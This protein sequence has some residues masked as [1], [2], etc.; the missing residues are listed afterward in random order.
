MLDDFFRQTDYALDLVGPEH[1]A[2]GADIFE[3]STGGVGWRAVTGQLYP[4][5]SQGMTYET[6]NIAGFMR[7][8][9]FPA[10]FE[11]MLDHGYS[12][13]TVRQ[14]IGDNW[15]RVFKKVWDGV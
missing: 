4:E 15:V 1:V 12:E 13:Q 14:I 10:V 3:D 7:Q 6:H 11:R 5:V 2:I 9:D 8:T